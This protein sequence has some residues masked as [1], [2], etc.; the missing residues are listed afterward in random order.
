M[1]F[2]TLCS[3]YEPLRFLPV[4]TSGGVLSLLQQCV[5]VTL[6]TCS[7]CRAKMR[8]NYFLVISAAAQAAI[9]AKK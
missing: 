7:L 1:Q 5:R 8:Y 6:A 3:N 9:K 4:L 2:V